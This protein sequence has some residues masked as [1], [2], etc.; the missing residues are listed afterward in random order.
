M[1][2]QEIVDEI[3]KMYPPEKIGYNIA[4]IV[5]G[6][7]MVTSESFTSDPIEKVVDYYHYDRGTQQEREEAMDLYDD[8]GVSRKLIDWLDKNKLWAEWEH[9][10]GVHIYR[11]DS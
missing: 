11:N 5:D 8:F 4:F 6:K 10:G 2:D 3:N 9:A 7:P 1:T